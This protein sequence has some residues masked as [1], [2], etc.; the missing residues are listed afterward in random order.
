M[1]SFRNDGWR[2]LV[3]DCEGVVEHVAHSQFSSLGVDHLGRDSGLDVVVFSVHDLRIKVEER[4]NLH[5]SSEPD[6]VHVQTERSSL[7][8]K[9]QSVKNTL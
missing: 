5:W 4:P 1:V 2:S 7:A 8:E 9:H 6:V 3:F